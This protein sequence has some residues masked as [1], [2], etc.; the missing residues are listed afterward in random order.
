MVVA[1]AARPAVVRRFHNTGALQRYAGVAVDDALRDERRSAGQ[2]GF[3]RRVDGVEGGG[4]V[5][6]GWEL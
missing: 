3:G 2:L 4:S 1:P 6:L 5:A